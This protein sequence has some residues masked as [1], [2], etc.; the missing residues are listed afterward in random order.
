MFV[1]TWNALWA[2][3][4]S[5]DTSAEG[6]RQSSFFRR[7]RPWVGVAVGLGLLALVVNGIDTQG[8]RLAWMRADWRYLL[9]ALVPVVGGSLLRALRWRLLHRPRYYPTL[10][11]TLASVLAGQLVNLV[12]PFRA[13]ELVRVYYLA[14]LTGASKLYSL[15]TVAIERSLDALMVLALTGALAPL[16]I[17][18]GWLRWSGLSSAAAFSAL[19]AAMVIGV[20]FR[21]SLSCLVRRA[22]EL[23]PVLEKLGLVRRLQPAADALDALSECRLMLAV[24]G[25]SCLVWLCG[26]LVNH[27]VLLS[28][29][30]DQPF[31][32]SLFVLLA[33]TLG[34]IVP[35][36]P[37]QAGVFETVAVLSLMSFGVDQTT[38]LAYGLL[39]HVVALGPPTV[40]GVFALRY[41]EGARAEV[42]PAPGAEAMRE[43]T[44]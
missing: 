14:E 16:V 10:R 24:W 3:A 27:L 39:L 43:E 21:G 42:G 1:R 33:L 17:F 22:T 25:L 2:Q 31:S 41:L 32:T 20:R 19:L 15:S 28:L 23:A 8:L 26:G 13:G 30:L 11:A 40:L 7:A 4:K 9:V 12:V 18:P 6:R 36:L 38:G 35:S 44:A 5:E 34:A 37:W 29:G